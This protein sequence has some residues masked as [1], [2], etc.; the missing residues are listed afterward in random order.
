MTHTLG[1]YKFQ[2]T[3]TPKCQQ[4]LYFVKSGPGKKYILVRFT[5]FFCW[6]FMGKLQTIHFW[7]LLNPE[8]NVSIFSEKSMAA[9]LEFHNAAMESLFLRYFYF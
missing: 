4:Q 7:Y 5:V 1:W 3:F 9:I 2:N 6:Y 8:T